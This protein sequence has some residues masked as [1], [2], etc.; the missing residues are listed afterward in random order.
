V[1]NLEVYEDHSYVGRG[2]V[3]HNCVTND[4]Q[5]PNT[6]SGHGDSFISV[7]LAVGV[8]FDF[9]AV[10]RKLGTSFIG[11]MQDIIDLDQKSK[12]DMVTLKPEIRDKLC[13]VCGGARFEILP[14]GR[15]KCEKCGTI[16]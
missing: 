10:D 1:Y 8:Y 11:N 16:W 7:M 4:L 12:P 6:P 14:D 9:Y 13:K 5:A 2:I 3:F 15:K